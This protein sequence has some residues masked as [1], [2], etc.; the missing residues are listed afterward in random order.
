VIIFSF[1][2][3]ERGHGGNILELETATESAPMSGSPLFIMEMI[4]TLPEAG[5]AAKRL[6]TA[7]ETMARTQS[8]DIEMD[9]AVPSPKGEV[10]GKTGE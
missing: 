1:T 5:G 9:A 6:R 3:A 2:E 4:F 7:L 8:V 10:A